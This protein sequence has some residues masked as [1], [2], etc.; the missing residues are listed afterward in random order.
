MPMMA[1][2]KGFAD[3]DSKEQ[4]YALKAPDGEDRE[5]NG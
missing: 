5:L 1:K 3:E 4:A 2:E